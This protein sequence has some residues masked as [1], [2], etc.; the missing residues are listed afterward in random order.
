M[1]SVREEAHCGS[2]FSKQIRW[3][4]QADEK[5]KDAKIGWHLF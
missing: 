5:L 3:H 2:D 4:V 1:L